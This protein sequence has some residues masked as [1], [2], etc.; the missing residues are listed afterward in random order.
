VKWPEIRAGALAVV[1]AFGLVDGCPLP[2]P[3][4]TP[5]W[6]RGFVEPI[7]TVQRAVLT[8]V[9]W[10]RTTVRITQRFALFQAADAEGVRFVIEGQDA[11]HAWRLLYRAGDPDHDAYADLIAYRR[12]R[13]VLEPIDAV[14]P[15]YQPFCAWLGRRI[16][17][18]DPMLAAVRFRFEK[19]HLEPGE[20]Q[21]TGAFE[22]TV[23][24]VR[25]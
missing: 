21:G 14:S 8:P 4:D 1:I 19:I 11:S 22:H 2:A 18:D 5:G 12:V 3:A 10:L 6:E 16:F 25:R 7:R 20:V 17:A 24:K 15:S 9:A 13:G 23:V